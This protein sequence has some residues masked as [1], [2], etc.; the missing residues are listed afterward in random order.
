MLQT[1]WL[2][3]SDES[4]PFGNL[5]AYDEAFLEEQFD[6]SYKSNVK[7]Q[8]YFLC[9]TFTNLKL[10]SSVELIHRVHSSDF[11]SLNIHCLYIHC[12]RSHSLALLS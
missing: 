10:D 7:G 1:N 4:L 5:V 3:I 2:A 12:Q 9:V 8:K 11:S 6:Q